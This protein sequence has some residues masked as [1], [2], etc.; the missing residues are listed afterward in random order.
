MIAI[1][2][3]MHTNA[4]VEAPPSK[5]YTNRAL[6]IAAL[7]KGKSILKNPLFSDD[8][9]HMISALKQFGIKILSKK[10][11]IIVYGSEGKIKSPKGKIF[12]GNAGTT[13]RFITAL[14]CLANGE[15][16]ITGNKRMQE[17][18]IQD[19]IDGL[20]QLGMKVK[21]NNGFPPVTVAGGGLKGGQIKL[22]GDISSQYLSSI[23]M[24]APYAQGETVIETGN[25]ASRPYV[26]MTISV[27]E[28]FGTKI[29]NKN[30][31][32]F[33]VSNKRKYKARNYSIEG[34]ASNASYFF[35]AAAITKGKIRVNNINPK[36]KQG[37]IEF[38][39]LLSRMGCL[40]K[41][42]RN[43]IEVTG[44]P[45][46]AIKVD[47]NKMPDIVPTLA[48]T[49]L[50]A[51]GET[52]IKNVP[53]LRVKETDRLRALASELRKIGANVEEFPGGLKIRKRRLQKAI[54]ETYYDH[55]MA[56]SFAVAGLVI[57]GVRILN[58]GC[59]NK[60]FPNFWNEF[61]KLYKK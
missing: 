23:L 7:S 42:G 14:A 3:K 18:P 30:Y 22:N 46:S 44:K 4:A 17:R 56:M 9:N 45:L 11:S 43:F 25:L 41:N 52:I 28:D 55:R 35:A 5:S 39:G 59:V 13:M 1:K 50:F 61:Q 36:S 20:I 27:M 38:V 24:C 34:D 47:M 49:S 37:D 48:V 21:S 6:L 10:K 57:N 8:T 19:L 31:R 16:I 51:K 26:D 54:I 2:T 12:V 33:I 53:N 58:P 32:K 40:V 60:S 29:E 15:T